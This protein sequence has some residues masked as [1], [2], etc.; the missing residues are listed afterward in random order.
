MAEPQKPS[1]TPKNMRRQSASKASQDK[2]PEPTVIDGDAVEKPVESKAAPSATPASG[3]VPSRSAASAPKTSGQNTAGQKTTGQNTPGQKTSEAHA[4]SAPQKLDENLHQSDKAAK[5]PTNNRPRSGAT[6]MPPVAA[7]VVAGM[8]LVVALM[9]LAVSVVTYWQTSEQLDEGQASLAAFS[10][11]EAQPDDGAINARLDALAALIAINAEH[12]AALQEQLASLP[13]QNTVSDQMPEGQMPEGQMPESRPAEQVLGDLDSRL[14]ALEAKLANMAPPTDEAVVPVESAPPSALPV[15]FDHA[16]L[17]LL[18]AAGLLSEN[19]AGRGLDKWVGLFDE[20]AW[21]G[22]AAA[23][24]DTIRA[25]GVTPAMSRADLLADGRLQLNRMVQ[26]LNRADADDGILDET[27]A[28][29]GAMVSLRRVGD[30]SD[31]PSAMLTAF[32][33]ALDHA[34]FEA[35]FAAARQWSSSGLDGLDSWVAAAGRRHDLD[36]AVNRLVAEFL[37][38]ATGQR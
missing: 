13:R 37:S 34:D 12:A 23:D 16:Q 26:S 36:A 18:A 5:K 32:E 1:G 4:D 19:M 2:A 29:L 14:A 11:N 22:I 3:S 25:A 35:A 9:A 38:G 28:R 7:M 27:L 21:P 24:R 15:S 31:Q 20:L 8:A 10:A 33:T 6:L 17:G 30:G